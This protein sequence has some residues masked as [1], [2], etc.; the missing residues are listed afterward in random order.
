MTRA[1]PHL[2]ERLARI[3]VDSVRALARQRVPLSVFGLVVTTVLATG[4]IAIGALDTNPLRSTISVQ[5]LLPESGGLMPNQNVTFRGVPVGHVT[6]VAFTR[7]GVLATAEINTS[8]QVPADSLAHVSALSPAGEQYLDFRPPSQDGDSGPTRRDV[9]RLADGAVLTEDIDAIPVTL[10]RLLANSDGVLGQLDPDK[11]SAITSE[12]R[13]SNQG[14][15]KLADLFDGGS[16]LISTVASVLPQTMS[17]LRN[18]RQVLTLLGDVTP[19]L[20]HSARN[21]KSILT[22]INAM[23]G[24]FRTLM[25]RGEPTLNAIDGLIDDNSDTMV[26]LLGSLT[27]IAQLTTVRVPALRQMIAAPRGSALAAI[28]DTLHD[29]YVMAIADV[30]PRYGCDYQLPRLSPFVASYPEPYLYTYCTNPDPAV[31]VRGARN[32]PRPPGDDT[33]GPPPGYDPLAQAVPAPKVKSLMPTPYGGSLF[34]YPL[35]ADPP[36]YPLPPNWPG[37]PPADYV[38]PSPSPRPTDN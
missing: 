31:L 25:A 13:V 18:S 35:P 14:P 10:A 7:H 16:F 20:D 2:A 26:S 6:S 30:Y 9:P 28:G 23:D 34:P 24:G 38:E 17:V 27:T 37:K 15:A 1:N 4:Y 29:G 21:L 32:A 36:D 11:L 33:A 19:G 5:V 12:L 8:A 3:T 22:G